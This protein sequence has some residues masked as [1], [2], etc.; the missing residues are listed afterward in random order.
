MAADPHWLTEFV[1]SI[2]LPVKYFSSSDKVKDQ[3]FQ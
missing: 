2:S 1:V 3:Y